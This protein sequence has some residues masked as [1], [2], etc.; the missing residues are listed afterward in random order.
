MAN[1]WQRQ[2]RNEVQP[3]SEAQWPL[4]SDIFY[5]DQSNDLSRRE[6]TVVSRAV[7]EKE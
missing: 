1:W 6:D 2:G 3:A 5:L 7:F 4:L